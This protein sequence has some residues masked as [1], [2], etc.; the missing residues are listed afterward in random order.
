MRRFLLAAVVLGL[1]AATAGPAEADLIIDQ[2]QVATE[3]FVFGVQFFSPIGQSFTPTFNGIDFAIFGLSK[4]T[5]APNPIRVEVRSGVNG[6]L[7]GTSNPV[8]PPPGF[9]PI[10]FEFDFPS[11][12]PLTPGQKFS[13]ILAPENPALNDY[14]LQ[15]GSIDA[16]YQGGGLIASGVERLSQQTFFKE[17][18]FST[19]VPEPST[20]A[21]AGIGGLIALGAAWRRRRRAT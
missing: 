2:S 6:A 21:S 14:G 1:A 15:V 7:L 17:G 11:T 13:L 5:P 18:V 4:F 19:A 8:S 12:V 10:E 16:S 20:L 3:G 9:A